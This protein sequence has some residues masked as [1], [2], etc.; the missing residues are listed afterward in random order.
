MGWNNRWG[1]RFVGGG[2]PS[3][4]LKGELAG[5]VSHGRVLGGV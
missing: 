1:V 3:G 5:E 2:V 4:G